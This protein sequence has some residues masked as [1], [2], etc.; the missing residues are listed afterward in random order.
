MS[1]CEIWQGG[2]GGRTAEIEEKKDGE[3]IALVEPNL[4]PSSS[5]ST[6][7]KY[8]MLFRK[9]VLIRPFV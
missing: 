5:S 9:V 6:S 7:V 1:T 2:G 3:A 4:P 8:E